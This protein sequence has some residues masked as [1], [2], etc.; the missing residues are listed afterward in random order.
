MSKSRLPGG[1]NGRVCKEVSCG[2]LFPYLLLP[3]RD[4][5]EKSCLAKQTE[6]VEEGLR[7]SLVVEKGGRA[8]VGS[9][10]PFAL[11]LGGDGGANLGESGCEVV[12]S[13]GEGGAG[14]ADGDA[15]EL[16]A[17]PLFAKG[18]EEGEVFVGNR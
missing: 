7:N 3:V 16:Y 1:W 11:A 14:V 13:V 8:C 4:V 15:D 18:C 12:R 6:L 5:S 2:V 10:V 17:S 9:L